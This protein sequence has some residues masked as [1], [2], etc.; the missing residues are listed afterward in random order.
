MI[1][2]LADD[3]V[4]LV[5][6]DQLVNP[7]GT[8]LS[9]SAYVD[10][11]G[12]FMASETVRAVPEQ[13]AASALIPQSPDYDA[14]HGNNLAPAGLYSFS[15][16]AFDPSTGM[17]VPDVSADV[18]VVHQPAAQSHI[19]VNLW[20]SG[21]AGLTARS[22]Q[23]SAAFQS[24]ICTFVGLWGQGPNGC[25][26]GG[27]GTLGLTVDNITYNDLPQGFQ[28]IAGDST[29]TGSEPDI[30]EL[31]EQSAAAPAPG[32]DFYF[33]DD[34]D[35]DGLNSS[36]GLL[37]IDGSIPSPG[38]FQGT[39]RSGAVVIMDRVPAL[40]DNAATDPSGLDYQ[41][42][43]QQYAQ[44]IAHEGGHYLGLFHTQES[45]CQP[46]NLSDTPCDAS[47]PWCPDATL[48][49]MSCFDTSSSNCTGID[50]GTDE[51]VT[52][53]YTM[54]WGADPSYNQVFFSAEQGIAV[55]RHPL[56][57]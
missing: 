8:T 33:I 50:F 53:N 28:L 25:G 11:N 40:T 54:F 4:N 9:S 43:I 3:P 16:S 15:I 31:F 18:F 32:V 29:R 22:A 30:V 13:G 21:A 35:I 57:H 41:Q 56:V 2:A 52:E 49:V 47:C 46:D 44:V 5:L 17:G 19:N 36:A 51:T 24:I 10:G 45:D 42:E 26:S 6:V 14:S 1:I 55:R 38:A 20:F 12:D 48:G 34:I 7:D 27:A 37:G 23:T 39:P